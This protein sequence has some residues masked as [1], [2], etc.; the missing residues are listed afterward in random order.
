MPRKWTTNLTL[1]RGSGQVWLA[2]LGNGI[3]PVGEM[4]DVNPFIKIRSR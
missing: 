2:M 3:A 4:K 1:I